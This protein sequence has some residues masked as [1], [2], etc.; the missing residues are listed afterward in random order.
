MTKASFGLYHQKFG[1]G[2]GHFFLFFICE[3]MPCEL[4]AA[5][6]FL[7]IVTLDLWSL[8]NHRMGRGVDVLVD[9]MILQGCYLHDIGGICK[10]FL[11]N[12]NAKQKMHA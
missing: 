10:V 12:S 1:G 2:F 8:P 6:L 7:V 3:A 5:R 9:G 4:M 11:C